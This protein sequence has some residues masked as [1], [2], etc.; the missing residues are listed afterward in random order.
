MIIAAIEEILFS[1]FQ[2]TSLPVVIVPEDPLI[3]QPHKQSTGTSNMIIVGV[4]R[5]SAL[6]LVQDS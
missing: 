4:D 5:L 6:S 2:H 3:K 1:M